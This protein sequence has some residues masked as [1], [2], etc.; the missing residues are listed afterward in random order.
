MTGFKFFPHMDVY[1]TV[2]VEASMALTRRK[3][4]R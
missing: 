4:R 3:R 2:P 1:N